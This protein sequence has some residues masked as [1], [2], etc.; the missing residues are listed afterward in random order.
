MELKPEKFWSGG[1]KPHN[2]VP[3]VDVFVTGEQIKIAIHDGVT[4]AIIEIT[5]EDAE[6]IS[7]MLITAVYHAK[8]WHEYMQSPPRI[9]T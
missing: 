9:T 2:D 8:E 3:C 7:N 6:K 5:Q 1:T 4:F